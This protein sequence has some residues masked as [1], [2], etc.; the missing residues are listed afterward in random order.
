MLS[1]IYQPTKQ[2]PESLYEINAMPETCQPLYVWYGWLLCNL[3][4][5]NKWV[6]W[7]AVVVTLNK[8]DF[9]LYESMP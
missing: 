7:F 9:R 6:V 8:I 1:T 4:K 3:N 2:V 5:F